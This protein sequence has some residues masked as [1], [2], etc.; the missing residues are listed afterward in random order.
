[1][2]P[3]LVS[4]SK[5]TG[6]SR[7]AAGM[8][9]PEGPPVCTALNF[10]PPLGPPPISSMIRRRLMPMGTSTRPV[11]SILPTRLKTLVPLEPSVPMPA[12]QAPPRLTMCGTLAQVST[13]FRVVGQPAQAVLD[14]VDVLGARLP[15]PPFQGGH[16][17]RGLAADEGAAAAVD[18][19]VEGEAAAQ[20]VVAQQAAG[21]GVGDGLLQ[22]LHRQRVLV[23]HVDVAL[24][25]ADGEGP[26]DHALQHRVRVAF[27]D[28]AVHER[29][30]VAL[31]AV[32][33][34]VLGLAGRLPAAAPLAPRGEAAAAAAAQAGDL[35]LP[36]DL[37]PA[38]W[39]KRALARPA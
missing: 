3:S 15:G 38:S 35:H 4:S 24:R 30:G 29:A 28:R 7:C 21:A 26:D 36:D 27:H 11:F 10:L 22:M 18:A 1:M 19:D 5:S 33:D 12:N 37:A 16:Q 14:R 17:G 2:E 34:H 23:A 20:D 31:V 25:G 9:P 39:P 32:A 13:L 8:Q 6:A